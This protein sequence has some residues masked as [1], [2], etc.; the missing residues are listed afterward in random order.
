MSSADRYP[1][2]QIGF[3]CASNSAGEG[4]GG[5]TPLNA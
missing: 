4:T 2:R 1:R 3:V 5:T